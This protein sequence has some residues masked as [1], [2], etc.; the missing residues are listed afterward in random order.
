MDVK[1]YRKQVAAEIAGAGR[2]DRP[3]V[4]P[5]ADL[6]ATDDSDP[7]T[8]ADSIA[9]LRIDP[10]NLGETVPELLAIVR[11]GAQAVPVR[12]AAFR[13]LA[14]AAF[15][16]PRFAP[17][18]ADYLEALRE[19]SSDPDA[20][21]RES[22]LETLAIEKDAYAQNVLL[23]GL[24]DPKA[25]LV[26]P[27]RAIQFLGYDVHADVAPVVRELFH[28]SKGAVKEEAL[29]LLASDPGSQKLITDVMLDKGERSAM[30]RLGAT[31]LQNLNPEA[32]ERAARRIVTD[33]D[34]YDAIRATSLAALAHVQELG[35][36]ASD[37]GF[38]DAVEK[39]KETTKSPRLRSSIKRFMSA[40]R[41]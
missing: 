40:A 1:E 16:G 15:L 23:A 31:A 30:R 22:A 12:M 37:A 35:T 39:L 18:R 32:F 11:D 6:A 28:R 17:F 34:D 25:A 2:D 21:L 3:A 27:A 41:G 24:K 36:A 8:R 5:M 9:A 7:A 14:G 29:R 19:V 10:Q 4:R 38:A 13:V 33:E 20:R 26:P